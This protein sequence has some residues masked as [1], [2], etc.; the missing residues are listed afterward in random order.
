MLFLE[1][2]PSDHWTQRKRE[3]ADEVFDITLSE[4]FYTS[5]DNKEEVN[6][7]LIKAIGDAVNKRL[8]SFI[9]ETDV[10]RE[11][12]N[13]TVVATVQLLRNKKTYSPLLKALSETDGVKS[14]NLGNSYVAF[15]K[16][17]V[18]L[19]LLLLP[20]NQIT[21]ESLVRRA[22]NHAKKA[23]NEILKPE[24]VA[25]H[26]RTDSLTRLS[27][28]HILKTSDEKPLGRITDP[29]Q[30]P[31]KVR[32]DYRNSSESQESYFTH[33]EYGKGK[34]IA[35]EEGMPS[36]GIWDSITVKFPGNPTPKIFN[37]LYTTTYF[38]MHPTTVRECIQILETLT[39]KRVELA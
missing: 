10:E 7:K 27:A 6:A 35:S 9:H 28:D 36:T 13:V 3:R 17:D 5:D 20:E 39:G 15:T 24:D 29:S 14:E 16:D 11:K 8:V 32:G 12:Y 2:K 34:I 30:L 26:F 33:K 21:K 23:K 18:L 19:T 38:R 37:R 22:I 1:Y 25:V 31:Y 4:D